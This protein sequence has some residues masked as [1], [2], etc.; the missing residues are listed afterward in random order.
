METAKKAAAAAGGAA[1]GAKASIEKRA[2]EGDWSGKAKSARVAAS[3]KTAEG[4]VRRSRIR[5]FTPSGAALLSAAR[6]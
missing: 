2:E 5:L 3:K 6:T 1:A 4:C